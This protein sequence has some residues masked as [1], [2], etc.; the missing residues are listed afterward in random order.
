MTAERPAFAALPW[1]DPA[2]QA[3]AVRPLWKPSC[4]AEDRSPYRLRRER[5]TM[6]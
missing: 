3:L 1:L 2:S 6:P 5:P 4:E